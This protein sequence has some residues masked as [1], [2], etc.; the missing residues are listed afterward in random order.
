ML[1]KDKLNFYHKY[2]CFMRFFLTVITAN[3]LLILPEILI[4]ILPEILHTAL[5]SKLERVGALL[6]LE[7][8]ELKIKQE[9]V[10]KD[11]DV[12]ASIKTASIDLLR[13]TIQVAGLALFL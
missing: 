3:F 2:I 6:G 13:C 11:N 4:R 1:I 8:N 7:S 9:E 10:E 12:V 5:R